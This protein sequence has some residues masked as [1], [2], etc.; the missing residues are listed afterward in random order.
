L[1]ILKIEVSQKVVIFII[2]TMRTSYVYGD[3]GL[4]VVLSVTRMCE[5]YHFKNGYSGVLQLQA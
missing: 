2:T 1:L 5:S 4:V 3:I